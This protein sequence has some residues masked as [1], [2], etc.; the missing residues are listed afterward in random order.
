MLKS[1]TRDGTELG[2]A[3]KLFQDSRVEAAAGRDRRTQE[4]LRGLWS[5]KEEKDVIQLEMEA[6]KQKME[7]MG[8]KEHD[9][10]KYEH[11]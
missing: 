4:D 7:D 11:L 9:Q 5:E 6:I 8:K 10:I 2:S 3:P 1:T